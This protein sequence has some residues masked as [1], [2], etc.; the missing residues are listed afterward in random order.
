VEAL[1]GV[2]LFIVFFV[3]GA[4]QIHLGFIGIE[5]EIGAWA[6]WIA[7]ALFFLGRIMPPLTIG[8]YFGAVSV[9]GWEWWQGLL[10][11]APGLLF[12]VPALVMVAVEPIL[13]R[14]H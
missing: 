10:I 1:I 4:V 3:V 7:I 11:A 9:W 14:R 2:P 6:A 12:I 13:H 5:H 8:S